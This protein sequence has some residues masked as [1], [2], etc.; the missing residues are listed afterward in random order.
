M[1]IIFKI[2]LFFSDFN[3]TGPLSSS[4]S[5]SGYHSSQ[6][7]RS[8]RSP[9]S[10]TH[11]SESAPA[12]SGIAFNSFSQEDFLELDERRS[13][14]EISP[15]RK[16]LNMYFTFT[17]KTWYCL[18]LKHSVCVIVYAWLVIKHILLLISKCKSYCTPDLSLKYIFTQNWRE[19]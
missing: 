13:E 3:K 7:D 6:S 18:V 5:S 1:C 10:H 12:A 15:E 14:G 2:V 4:A 9:T 16:V 8:D 17:T 11:L 19:V